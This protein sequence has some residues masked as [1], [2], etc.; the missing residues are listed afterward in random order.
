MKF[1]FFLELDSKFDSIYNMMPFTKTNVPILLHKC[2]GE[3]SIPDNEKIGHFN[4]F[5]A[6][7]FFPTINMDIFF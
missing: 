1:V 3:N 2:M 5:F 4:L 7:Y 6:L